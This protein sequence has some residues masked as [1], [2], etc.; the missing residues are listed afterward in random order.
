MQVRQSAGSRRVGVRA[1]LI[2]DPGELVKTLIG[3]RLRLHKGVIMSRVPMQM[4][5]DTFS[6]RCRR[7]VRPCGVNR[8]VGVVAVPTSGWSQLMKTVI[9][10]RRRCD[11]GVIRSR[12]PMLVP[13][14]GSRRRW[15]QVLKR[16]LPRSRVQMQVHRS[17][18][19]MQGRPSVRPSVA[20]APIRVVAE[21]IPDPGQVVSSPL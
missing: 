10:S 13:L 15:C 16:P 6:M 18:L 14:I 9:G 8:R 17:I 4:R 20:T 1:E 11:M 21:H 7:P 2:P 12:P 3:S 19:S 5:P